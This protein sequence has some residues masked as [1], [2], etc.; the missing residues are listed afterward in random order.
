MNVAAAPDPH[1]Q[2]VAAGPV[3]VR[4]RAVFF[5]PGYDPIGPRRY[6]ELYRRQG[7][8]QAQ[9]SGYDLRIEALA[10]RP[11]RYGWRASLTGDGHTGTRHTTTAVIEV[12]TWTDIVRQSMQASIPGTYALM[13][14]VLLFYAASGALRALWRLR[15]QPML[16]A[17][18]PVAMLLAQLGLALL[19]G[20]IAFGVTAALPMPL[21]PAAA[22]VVL[23]LAL[24][25]FR[26][27]DRWLYA[28]YLVHD[29]A[30][31]ASEGGRMPAPLQARLDSFAARVAEVAASPDRPDEILIVGHSSGAALA[32]GLLA[33][34]RRSVPDGAPAPAPGLALLTLG[35]AI[36]MVSFLPEARQLRADLH[37]LAQDPGITW[38]D[39]SAPGDGACFALSDPV[40]VSGVAPQGD[41]RLWPRVISAAFSRTLSAETA[42][43]TRF[44]FFRR[45]IQY[46]CA[47]ERADWYDYFQIT[48][49]PVRLSD[50]V[51]DR[52]DS[53]SRIGTPLSP[54][55]GF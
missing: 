47:F 7:Q 51:R 18:Y 45:H 33:S 22:L 38:V 37:L 15:P 4:R 16:A 24:V 50:R 26:R 10:P 8:R 29:Y 19:A 46:L 23:A 39:V 27:A 32:V 2:P 55:R 40:A 1:A 49:G 31:T 3:P 5:I 35:H 11:G 30:F 20:R 41:C 6:R 44:S 43:R 36:P 9:L 52:G 28:Y 42:R 53:R 34:L 14:K 25:L 12:L 54:H 21:P 17:V 13:L 48:A